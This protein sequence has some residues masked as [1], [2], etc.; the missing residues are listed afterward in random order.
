MSLVAQGELQELLSYDP[1]TGS[2]RWR[3]DVS[4]KAKA[5]CIA[6]SVD[7]KM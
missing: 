3:K 7:A 1:D 6:G 4:A 5:S 2:F